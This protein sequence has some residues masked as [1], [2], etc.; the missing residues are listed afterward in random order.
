M[1][2]KKYFIFMEEKSERFSLSSLKQFVVLFK[3]ITDSFLEYRLLLIFP[4]LS[5]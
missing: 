1:E 3:N 5:N 4:E 2:N